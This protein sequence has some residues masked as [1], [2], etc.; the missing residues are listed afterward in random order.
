VFKWEEVNTEVNRG[1]VS[2]FFSSESSP[3]KLS[4]N[5]CTT[6]SGTTWTEFYKVL[7]EDS[8]SLPG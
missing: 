6:V 5:Q 7:H 4:R 1:V 8:S 3:F 2:W